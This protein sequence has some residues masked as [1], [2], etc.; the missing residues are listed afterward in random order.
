MTRVVLVKCW[1]GNS[2][3]LPKGKIN[4]GEP[5][6]A[7]ALRE[8]RSTWSRATAVLTL[9]EWDAMCMVLLLALLWL[10]RHGLARL[11]RGVRDQ[12]GSVFGH[13]WFTY[14]FRLV[15]SHSRLKYKAGA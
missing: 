4:Q 3:G 15:C 10:G 11:A 7:A 9:V 1:K 6:I 8:V 13:V 12:A 14:R 2:R 5:A